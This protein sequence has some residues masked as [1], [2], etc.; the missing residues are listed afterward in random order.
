MIADG[1]RV[2]VA[3]SGGK[4]SLSLLQLLDLR[5]E[6]AEERCELVAIH[7]MGDSRGPETPAHPP[8]LDWLAARGYEFCV[9]TAGA[10]AGR[11]ASDGLPA[12]HLEPAAGIVRSS[13][14]VG[15]QR[16][17]LRASRRRPG[18]DHPAQ[19]AL[20]RQGRNDGAAPGLLRR[21]CAAGAA[22]VFYGR[23]GYPPL[24]AG[25]RL[26]PSAAGLPAQWPLKARLARQLLRLAEKGS[27]SARTNLLRAGLRGNG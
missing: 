23:E 11:G 19:P 24:C 5:R 8:L 6:S 27:R 18:P 17:G 9:R 22:A 12:L 10:G 2:A 4:D 16:S 25:Q 15:L 21:G 14:A 3:V 13:P 26:S 20:P 7:V 1:D